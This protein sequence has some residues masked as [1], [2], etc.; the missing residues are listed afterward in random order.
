[1]HILN[2]CIVPPLLD[3]SQY[4]NVNQLNHIHINQIDNNTFTITKTCCDKANLIVNF[5]ISLIT[6]IPL[7]IIGI[8]FDYYYPLLFGIFELIYALGFFILMF[9]FFNTINFIIGENNITVEEIAWL[10]KKVTNY[11]PG[12]LKSVQL[13]G[14]IAYE[15]Q[16]VYKY[17]IS[18]IVNNNGI[19]SEVDYFKEGKSS[20]LYTPEEIGYFNYVMNKHIQTK[21]MVKNVNNI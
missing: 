13:N 4:T 12:Q 7:I 3:Y 20:Q 8:Y 2:Q 11:L 9:R 10:R 21:M 6:G 15:C 17:R 16:T 18:F 1:M 14:E 19:Y 5:I